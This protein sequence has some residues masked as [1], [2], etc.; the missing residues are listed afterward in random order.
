MANQK[1]I[2]RASDYTVIATVYNG[3]DS[4]LLFLDQLEDCLG[5]L[6]ATFSVLIVDDAS[7]DGTASHLKNFQFSAKNLQLKVLHLPFHC[8]RHDSIAQG[9]LVARQFKCRQFIVMQA[10]GEDDPRAIADLIKIKDKDAVIVDRGPHAE[11]LGFWL[12]FRMYQF[13]FRLFTSRE[14]ITGVYSMINRR[15]LV[16]LTQQP[17]LH[18]T[19][20]LYKL[21]L[22]GEKVRLERKGSKTSFPQ[23]WQQLFKESIRSYMEFGEEL[24][25]AFIKLSLFFGFLIFA[26]ILSLLYINFFTDNTA[27]SWILI[28]TVGLISA[29]ILSM[30]TFGIG[31]SVLHKVRSHSGSIIAVQK[32]NSSAAQTDADPTPRNAPIR[33]K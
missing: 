10:D 4:I 25:G 7:V 30:G 22:R 17:F 23:E 21:K 32:E 18:Y 27:P 12:V 14:L 3:V 11:N 9:L 29:L 5:A 20:R 1:S 13:I 24:L 8:G 26:C 31:V 16:Q 15:T 19:A 28:T 2:F 33:L 6:Q